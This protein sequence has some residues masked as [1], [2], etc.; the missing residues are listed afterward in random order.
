MIRLQKLSLSLIISRIESISAIMR[1]YFLSRYF[2]NYERI[3]VFG[4]TIIEK[5][6]SK[7]WVEKNVT[8]NDKV[9]LAVLGLNKPAS[10]TIGRSTWIGTRVEIHCADNIKIGANCK[11]G[12][13]SII[14]DRDYHGINNDAENTKPVIIEDNVWICCRAIILK[15]VRIGE[16]AIV[17]AGSVVTK[18]VTPHTVVGGNPARIIKV[19]AK[20]T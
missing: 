12:W 2:E 18:D 3:Y 4:E 17:G 6:N 19:I 15:G 7:I 5:R 9:K 11:I 8:L 14:M 20:H 1:G 10:L 13:D 16:G